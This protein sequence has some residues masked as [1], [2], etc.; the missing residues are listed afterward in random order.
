MIAAEFGLKEAFVVF[1]DHR[2]LVAQLWS[3]FSAATLA[4]LG[5]TVGSDRATQGRAETH[6]IQVGYAVFALGNLCAIFVSQQ[7]V[8]RMARGINRLAVDQ[9]MPEFAGI[10][11]IPPAAFLVFHLLVSAAV[12]Y[13]IER[14]HRAGRPGAG[15]RT[16]SRG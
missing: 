5:F 11:P 10:T 1:N 12:L 4:V 9:K 15:S 7:E 8:E 14:K 3:F 13:A 16:A 6:C 2:E